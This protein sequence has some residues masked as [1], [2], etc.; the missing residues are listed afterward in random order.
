MWDLW[1]KSWGLWGLI[2]HELAKEILKKRTFKILEEWDC[3][4]SKL[5]DKF[6]FDLR[7]KANPEECPCYQQDKPCHNIENLNCLFCFCPNYN[8]SIE[9][10]GCKIN[11]PKGKYVYSPNGKIW[12][13][14][15]CDWPHK[16]ENIRSI[17]SEIYNLG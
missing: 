15:D 16:I 2:M 6:N 13:C 9:E 8:L 5:I 12:D 4:I 11:S 7:K 10:G 3:D 1:W 14:S 17:F